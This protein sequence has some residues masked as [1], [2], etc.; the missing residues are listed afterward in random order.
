MTLDHILQDSNN[1]NIA[2]LSH[3]TTKEDLTLITEMKG[4]DDLVVCKLNHDKVI[5]WL[6][7][8]VN[9]IFLALHVLLPN[10][11]DTVVVRG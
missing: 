2:K 6:E 10:S 9:M 4:E 5:S 7:K 1:E 11:G 8:K 3:C